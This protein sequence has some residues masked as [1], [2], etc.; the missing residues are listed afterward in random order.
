MLLKIAVEK[1]RFIEYHADH[2]LTE[3]LYFTTENSKVKENADVLGVI[4]PKHDDG[5]PFEMI[6][7]HV[8][9]ATVTVSRH[10]NNLMQYLVEAKADDGMIEG[11]SPQEIDEL[12]KDLILRAKRMLIEGE[13]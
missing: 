12:T 3:G 8:M 1:D 10:G 6:A 7:K 9:H 2:K 13:L 11:L 5:K 4:L